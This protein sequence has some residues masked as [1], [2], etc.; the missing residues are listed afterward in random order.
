MVV[1]ELHTRCGKRE[2]RRFFF[3]ANFPNNSRARE[4]LRY[5]LEYRGSD[6]LFRNERE[7]FRAACFSCFNQVSSV[8]DTKKGSATE[9]NMK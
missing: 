1:K 8:L 6:T 9:L 2:S 7:E 5:C 4:I 3:A